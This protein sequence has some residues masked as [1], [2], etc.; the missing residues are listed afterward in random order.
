MTSAL[1]F[2]DGLCF[3][4]FPYLAMFVFFLGTIMR[5][6]KAPFTYSSFSSQFLENKQHFWGL[7]PFHYGIVERHRPRSAV[8][9]QETATRKLE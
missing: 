3:I 8:C 9:F 1:P 4:V 5:Y 7:V 6:R 2:A